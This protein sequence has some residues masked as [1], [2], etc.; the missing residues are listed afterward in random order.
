M[1]GIQQNSVGGEPQGQ[2]APGIFNSRGAGKRGKVL[3]GIG[4]A[5]A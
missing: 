5:V 2:A 4:Q 3:L 1:T